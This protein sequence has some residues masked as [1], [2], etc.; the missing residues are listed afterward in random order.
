MLG[1]R[2]SLGL[3]AS[4][5]PTP[6]TG[7]LAPLLAVR[8]WSGDIG[9]GRALRAVPVLGLGCEASQVGHLCSVD[10]LRYGGAANRDL[11]RTAA[12]MAH[13][14]NHVGL[15]LPYLLDRRL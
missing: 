13:G 11:G 12:G 3:A 14:V 10:V 2:R 5:A 9:R 8:V 15:S 4:L 6:P 7:G 1:E